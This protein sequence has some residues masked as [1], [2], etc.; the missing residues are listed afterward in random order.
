MCETATPA[1]SIV[2]RGKHRQEEKAVCWSET[3]CTLHNSASHFLTCSLEMASQ[4]KVRRNTFTEISRQNDQLNVCI[5]TRRPE[6][7]RE[8]FLRNAGARR[9]PGRFRVRCACDPFH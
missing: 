3:R 8:F 5:D 1:S 6:S 2:R 4:A 9:A 7:L